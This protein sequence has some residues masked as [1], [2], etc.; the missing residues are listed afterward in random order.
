VLEATTGDA[1]VQLFSE[2]RDR[3]LA[4]LTDIRMP[5]MDGVQLARTVRRQAPGFPI[6][7]ITGYSDADTDHGTDLA[8][9]PLLAKPFSSARLLEVVRLAAASSPSVP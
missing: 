8:G 4:M 7:F 6:V 9:I 5:G 1:A 3:L 2:S